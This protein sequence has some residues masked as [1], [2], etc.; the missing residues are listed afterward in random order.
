MG[1]RWR[2]ILAM[3]SFAM[4]ALVIGVWVRSYLV[5]DSVWVQNWAE[6]PMTAAA[7]EHAEQRKLQGDF[8]GYFSFRSV[9]LLRG[10]VLIRQLETRNVMSLG[11]ER[12]PVDKPKW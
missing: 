7:R 11:R 12:E 4:F 2:G 9:S 5:Q 3:L 10:I 8:I 6:E 1:R